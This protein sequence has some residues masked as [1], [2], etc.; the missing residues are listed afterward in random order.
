MVIVG[1]LAPAKAGAGQRRHVPEQIYSHLFNEAKG[2]NERERLSQKTEIPIEIMDELVCLS[3]LARAYG[4]GP[5][6]ARMIY[7]VGIQSIKEFVQYTAEEIIRIYEEKEGKKADFGVN[8]IQFS[9]D[10]AKRLDVAD[11]I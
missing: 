6:S 9:L 11:E 2:I 1:K 8:E 10:L 3:D 4:V 5:V 7:D